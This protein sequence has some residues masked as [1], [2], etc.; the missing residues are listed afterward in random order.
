[1]LHRTAVTNWIT[2]AAR[3]QQLLARKTA[4]LGSAL[5]RRVAAGEVVAVSTG[6]VEKIGWFVEARLPVHRRGRCTVVLICVGLVVY[7]P[8]L[9]ISSPSG[10]PVLALAVLPLLPRATRRADLQREK[11]GRATEL[12][13][14]TVAG[15]A[16]CAASAAR[17][18]SS[19]ATAAPPRRSATPPCA[20]PV[21]G[22]SSPAVQVAAAGAADDRGRLARGA[23]RPRGPD[24]VGELVTV[25]SA[26]MLLLY[27]AAALRGDRDG[28]LLLPARPPNGPPGCC[29][30]GAGRTRHEPTGGRREASAVP[31]G[32]LYDPA[33]GLLAPA[34]RLTAVVCGDP[35]AAGRLAERLGGHAAE[36]GD[37]FRAPRRRTA[38]RTA[39][40]L[41]PHG[42]PRPGQGPGAALRH[43]ARTAR[44]ARLGRGHRRGALA[45]AQCG[46]VLDALVQGSPDAEDPMD[47][48]VTERGRSLSGGQRQRLALARSLITDPG[49]WCWTSRPPPSTR[50]PRR[51]SPTVIRSA[52]ERAARRSSSPPPAAPGPRRTGRARHAGKVAAV[53]P[54]PRPLRTEPP[55]RAVV[56]RETDE[57][58][59]DELAEAVDGGGERRAG[60]RRGCGPPS[61]HRRACPAGGERV[62]G[63]ADRWPSCRPE[64]ELPSQDWPEPRTPAMCWTTG[65]DQETARS[66]SRPRSYDPAAPTTAN[67][68]P[69][70]AP[71]TVR[72]YVAELFRRHS[73][74]SSAHHRQHVA[75]VA[76][77]AGPYLLGALV[78]DVSDGA[79]DLHLASRRPSSSSRS[80]S[81]P[82]FVRELRL[83][84]AML[85]EQMLADLREDFLVRSVALPP[86]VLERAGTGDLLSRITT[87]IDRLGNAMREAVPHLA[88][89]VV[90]VALLVGALDRHRSAARPRR[91][92]RLA[93]AAG[94]LPLVL[95]ARSVRLPLGGRRLRRRRRRRSPRRSTPAAPW[96]RTG[97]AHAASHLSDQRIR[98]GR[99]GSATRSGC[100]PCSSPSSTSPT[101]S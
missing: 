63:P 20:A 44:R 31:T 56:T 42:R 81:R 19:T 55:Y 101:C 10:V 11:A 99:P 82:F 40:R 7:Q 66:A 76:S 24:H 58:T 54:A 49:C 51:A 43:A 92:D 33:T 28:V 16:C 5:T 70:G 26:V 61:R 68:L 2:A 47:A 95:Q 39:P 30:A 98:S 46:D 14:D 36:E 69:V 37:A 90:W 27:P 83:R 3:V 73:G 64:E 6:D 85:G 71:A 59:A 12:A 13:S 25:Y 41:R 57:E 9:G 67:T 89:G 84:G 38:R 50:T 72:A 8:A 97:W 17:S 96:R 35:D 32:D 86:G 53:G 15:C 74:P 88:I 91:A 79:R 45:A 62:V 87:D 77:M 52:A 75:V 60:R 21:C 80:S 94:R 23:A 1:M 78:E 48:P 93:A 29:R 22:R 18:C 100:A 34:G 4:Q 65:R